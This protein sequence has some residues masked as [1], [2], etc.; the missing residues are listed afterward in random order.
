MNSSKWGLGCALVALL[1]ALY[2]SQAYAQGPEAGGAAPTAKSKPEPAPAEEA[3]SAEASKQSK[4]DDN[5]NAFCQCVDQSETAAVARIER[6]L[7]GPL[8]STGMEFTEQPL[9]DVINQLQEEYNI[10]IQIDVRELETAA[11]GIDAPINVSLHNISLK[12]GLKLLL[13]P[14]QLTYII[15]DEVLI[16]TTQEGA[17]KYL[18]TCVYNVQGLI[19]ESDP[20]SMNSL[21]DAIERCVASD[22]WADISD[23]GVADAMPIKPGL[24]VVSQTPA[25]QDEVRGLLMKIR[26]VREQV[27]ISKDRPKAAEINQKQSSSEKSAVN[28]ANPFGH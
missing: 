13:D 23:K 15:R 21:I 5:P 18:V 6:T 22:T 25:V 8:H 27:P 12:S 10:P 20:K 2:L 14:L 4:A 16:V 11:I 26:K 7:A 1:A 19:D 9:K 24:L 17:D 28:G 3:P